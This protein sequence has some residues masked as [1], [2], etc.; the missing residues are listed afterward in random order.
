MIELPPIDELREARQRLAEAQGEDAR[1]Y[2]AMLAEVA[3][4][5]SGTY[6]AK[7]LVPQPA[8]LQPAAKVS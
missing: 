8:P 4:T 5:L 6:I 2:A 7:P 3:R 1:R